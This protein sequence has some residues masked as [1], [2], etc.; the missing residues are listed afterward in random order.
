[1]NYTLKQAIGDLNGLEHGDPEYA[2]READAIL[3][4]YL[5]DNDLRDLAE[6]FAAASERVGFWYGS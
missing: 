4:D 3:V 2:H 1:M 5:K 6:A